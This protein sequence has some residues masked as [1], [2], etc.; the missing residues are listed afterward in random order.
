MIEIHPRLW[1]GN[2]DDAEIAIDSVRRDSRQANFGHGQVWA[3]VS[4][5]KEPYHRSLVGYT[6]RAAPE[7]P[8]R[9]SVRRG[10]HLALNWVDVDDPTWFHVRELEEACDHIDAAQIMEIDC[11]VHCNQGVSRSPSLALFWLHTR[12]GNEG[13]R[14]FDFESAEVRFRQLYP[15]YDPTEGVREFIRGQW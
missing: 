9:F 15:E 3:M 14:A 1:L 13:W 11:L 6:G 10:R 7:G 2:D 12:S 8:E 5:A 4:A